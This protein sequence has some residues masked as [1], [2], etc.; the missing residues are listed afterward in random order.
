[1]WNEFDHLQNEQ[2][3]ELARSLPAIVLQGKAPSTTKKYCGAFLRWK[4]WALDKHE[5]QVFP[6][7]PIHVALYLNFLIQKAKSSAPVVEA[8]N[9]LSW[10]HQL[11]TVEDPTEHSL[12]RQ[13]LAASKRILAHHTAKKEPITPEILSKLVDKFAMADASLSDI[14]TV[15]FCLLGYAGFFRFE[16]LAKLRESDV[17]IYA[18]HMEIFIESSKTDQYRDGA[19]VV[20]SRTNSKCCPV[21]MLERYRCMSSSSVSDKCLFRG[22]VHTKSGDKLRASGGL[23]YTRVREL[24]L[25]K[26][27]AI[28]LNKRQFGVHRLR[29]GGASAAAQA[30]VPDRWFKRHGRWRSE[31]AKDGYIKDNLQDRLQVSRSL[32]L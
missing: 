8:V 11:S 25:E 21:A 2:L 12:V 29:S 20:I 9:A 1:M 16:E 5:V 10:V 28:G 3:K 13:V 23:S 17:L 27:V 26:L 30:G 19:W 31:N 22:I 4:K 7:K 32:G 14:R 18:G 6:A 24:V 15:T